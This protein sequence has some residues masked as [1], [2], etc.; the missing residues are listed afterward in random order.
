MI[1]EYPPRASRNPGRNPLVYNVSS[2]KW[3][4]MRIVPCLCLSTDPSQST[5]GS[6][7]GSTSGTISTYSRDA[8]TAHTSQTSQTAQHPIRTPQTPQTPQQVC[9]DSR[10]PSVHSAAACADE[11]H[12]TIYMSGGVSL[13][14]RTQQPTIER[15]AWCLHVVPPVEGCVSDSCDSRAEPDDNSHDAST[16]LSSTFLFLPHSLIPPIQVHPPSLANIAISSQPI[17]FHDF[18][19]ILSALIFSQLEIKDLTHPTRFPSKSLPPPSP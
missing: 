15:T 9:S 6:T 5:S 1:G 13:T 10:E 12:M 18:P 4:T 7:T 17:C 14:Q 3:C 11:Q 19:L 2:A 16:L 8:Q